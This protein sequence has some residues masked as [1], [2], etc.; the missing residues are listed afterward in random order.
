MYLTRGRGSI[1]PKISRA[2]FQYR[3][4]P[5]LSIPR[6][7]PSLGSFPLWGKRETRMDEAATFTLTATMP[8][9]PLHVLTHMWQHLCVRAGPCPVRKG[10][11]VVVVA[12]ESHK[13]NFYVR[14]ISIERFYRLP[15]FFGTGRGLRAVYPSFP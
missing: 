15:L 13:T 2:S 6:F 1:S 8:P 10:G 11:C 5:P 12:G 7:A 4:L 3:P 9:P 14:D